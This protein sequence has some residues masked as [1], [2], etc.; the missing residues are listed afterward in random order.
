MFGW[1]LNTVDLKSFLQN[2]FKCK[3]GLMS[4]KQIS[5][6]YLLYTDWGKCQNCWKLW[7]SARP[8]V[9]LRPPQQEA[10]NAICQTGLFSRVK[11]IFFLPGLEMHGSATR[12]RKILPD[13]HNIWTKNYSHVHSAFSLCYVPQIQGRD[14]KC[15]LKFSHFY[16]VLCIYLVNVVYLLLLNAK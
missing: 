9:R 16:F 15:N 8:K 7:F 4:T 2:Q 1:F 6:F 11:R 5:N 10:S 13:T 12:I 14:R 3:I